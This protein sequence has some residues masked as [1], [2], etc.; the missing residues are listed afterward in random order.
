[1]LSV[2]LSRSF[3]IS[4]LLSFYVKFVLDM[5]VGLRELDTIHGTRSSGHGKLR[6]GLVSQLTMVY[7]VLL[8]DGFTEYSS[9]KS[10]FLCFLCRCKEM[11]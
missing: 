1:M 10:G 9:G 3:Y 8:L 5:L 11:P 6:K 7:M 2:Y 4:L